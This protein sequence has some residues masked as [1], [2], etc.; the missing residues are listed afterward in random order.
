MIFSLQISHVIRE[1]RHFQ[2]TPYKIEHSPKVT[3]YLLDPSR[4]LNDEDLYRTSLQIE[5]RRASSSTLSALEG[6]AANLTQMQLKQERLEKMEKEKKEK[7]RLS[8]YEESSTPP[9]TS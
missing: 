4:L 7:K 6:A 8:K 9:L 5:P 2:Q 3:K 1:I